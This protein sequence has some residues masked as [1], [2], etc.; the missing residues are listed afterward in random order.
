MEEAQPTDGAPSIE[1]QTS[2][3]SKEEHLEGGHL[4]IGIAVSLHMKIQF[5]VL[6]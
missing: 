1:R 5:W 6:L 3:G 4:Q 2:G